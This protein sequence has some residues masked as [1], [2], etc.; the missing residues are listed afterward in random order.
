MV[1]CDRVSENR[2]IVNCKDSELL[3]EIQDYVSSYN[4]VYDE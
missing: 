1:F 2:L 4:E 3:D